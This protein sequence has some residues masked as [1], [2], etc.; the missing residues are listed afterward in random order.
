MIG[1]KLEELAETQA[2][3]VDALYLLLDGLDSEGRQVTQGKFVAENF[4]GRLRMYMGALNLITDTIEANGKALEDI[5]EK[6]VT[7]NG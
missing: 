7:G 5:A 4:V 2:Q 6:E 3:A 1:D